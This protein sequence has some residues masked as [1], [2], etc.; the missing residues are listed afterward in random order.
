MNKVVYV[1]V[2]DKYRLEA[3]RSVQTLKNTN[4]LFTCLITDT[5]PISSLWD[6]VIILDNPS[7]SIKDKLRMIDC[8]CDKCLFI[9]SDT[10]IADNLSDIFDLLERFEIVA[11]QD[12]G[13]RSYKLPGVPESFPELNTGVLAF[14]RNENVLKFFDLWHK[15]F[16]LYESEMG[17]E[18]D[19]RSFRMAAFIT[20]IKLFVLPPEYNLMNISVGAAQLKVKIVHG[21]PF[22]E[23]IKI[24]Q[25]IN[26]KPIEQRVFVPHIGTIYGINEI[27]IIGFINLIIKLIWITSKEIIKRFRKRI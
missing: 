27:T 18:M 13:G 6:E 26:S 11:R 8:E 25:N 9:D 12:W 16:D 5:K 10:L 15:Y 22:N 21:R 17:R 19:Q 1:A 3:E 7:F 23:L 4:N 14:N 24:E 2:G 20:D